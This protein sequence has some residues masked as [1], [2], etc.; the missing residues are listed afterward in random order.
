MYCSKCGQLIKNEAAAFCAYCGAKLPIASDNIVKAA[1]PEKAQDN[2][3]Q[4]NENIVDLDAT[5]RVDEAPVK[6]YTL[7]H[8][9]FKMPEPLEESV[10][11]DICEK[12]EYDITA[13]KGIRRENNRSP[14]EDSGFFYPDSNGGVVYPGYDRPDENATIKGRNAPSYTVQQPAAAADNAYGPSDNQDFSQSVSSFSVQGNFAESFTQAGNGPDNF[15]VQQTP[16]SA[17]AKAR[18]KMPASKLILLIVICV[19]LFAAAVAGG[20]FAASAVMDKLMLIG[21]SGVTQCISASVIYI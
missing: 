14:F 21:A 9:Q 18:K 19:L 6:K 13:G 11:D 17:D 2:N 3:A 16:V 5:V 12:D 10:F 8:N 1:E 4:F 15:F 20:I 7:D